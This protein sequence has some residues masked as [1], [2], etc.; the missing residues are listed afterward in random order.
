MLL[1][2]PI[3]WENNVPHRWPD[4]TRP[5][6]ASVQ[7]DGRVEK[8]LQIDLGIN[9]GEKEYEYY[10]MLAVIFALG[11]GIGIPLLA[12][13][14]VRVAILRRNFES[15][16]RAFGFLVLGYREEMWYWEAVVMMRKLA[17]VFTVVFIQ[18]VKIQTYVGMWAMTLALIVHLWSRPYDSNLLINLEAFSLAVIIATL[19]FSLLYHWDLE[20]LYEHA[21]TAMLVLG[22]LAVF[23][24]FFYFL[25]LEGIKKLGVIV[26]TVRD[27]LATRARKAST[28]MSTV[29]NR[30]L[31]RSVDTQVLDE[32]E[33]KLAGTRMVTHASTLPNFD[34]LTL[35]SKLFVLRGGM[36]E[37]D[38]EDSVDNE[39][40]PT[41]HPTEK[42]SVK[43]QGAGIVAGPVLPQSRARPLAVPDNFEGGS[44]TGAVDS[45]PAGQVRRE[46]ADG[47]TYEAVSED[48]VEQIM[49]EMDVGDNTRFTRQEAK[50]EAVEGSLVHAAYMFCH[51]KNEG[52]SS[53]VTDK[54]AQSNLEDM[55]WGRQVS[56]EYVMRGREISAEE[57]QSLW[58]SEVMQ[59]HI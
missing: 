20:P 8:Y 58:N 14:I 9:C 25:A 1:C 15:A 36:Q 41:G 54:E 53:G 13:F 2:I 17:V 34:R 39:G 38:Y 37:D 59:Y 35:L 19:N 11:Y 3:H 27:K 40:V 12:I 55:E 50:E 28:S 18:D 43:W 4:S 49:S 46:E 26:A 33:K 56:R 32:T 6:V 42:P 29:M 16:K 48:T 51:L 7:G 5:E 30:V 44:A 24:L 10:R 21:L 31:R 52:V 22:T 47:R 45:R 57:F 23:L